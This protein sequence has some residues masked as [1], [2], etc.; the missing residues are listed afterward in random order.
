MADFKAIERGLLG[1]LATEI[2]SP[3]LASF[4]GQPAIFA[5]PAPPGAGAPHICL[6]N[7]IT[8]PDDTHDSRGEKAVFQI[9][10][11]AAR[12]SIIDDI[13]SEVDNSLHLQTFLIA[14]Y[15]TI[16]VQRVRGV[17]LLPLEAGEE[18][19]GKSADYQ[20]TVQE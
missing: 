17:A 20:L 13:F 9:N 12:M 18:L 5:Y 10:V 2:G 7:I 14:G 1:Y 8:M 19:V 15:E 6:F 11:W 16:A 3:P 4:Q